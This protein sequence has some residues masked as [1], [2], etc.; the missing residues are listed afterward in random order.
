MPQC[1]QFFN[2]AFREFEVS[3]NPLHSWG[4]FLAGFGTCGC[5]VQFCSLSKMSGRQSPPAL[6][7]ALCESGTT[8]Q[9]RGDSRRHSSSGVRNARNNAALHK[10]EIAV[11]S[12]KAAEIE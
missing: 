2:D 11:P 8:A 9:L 1:G 7:V 10:A 12:H 5:A 4:V 3:S 6:S